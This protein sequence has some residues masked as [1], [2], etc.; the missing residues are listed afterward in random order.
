[1]LA[2]GWRLEDEPDEVDV[3]LEPEVPELLLDAPA[4]EAPAA[5]VPVEAVPC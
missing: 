4:L 1:M 5:A 3:E 2:A